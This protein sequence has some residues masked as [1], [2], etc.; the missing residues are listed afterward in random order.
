MVRCAAVSLFALILAAA[1]TADAKC[2]MPATVFAPADGA[3]TAGVTYVFVPAYRGSTLSVESRHGLDTSID[4]VSETDSFRAY[5]V[6]VTYNHTDLEDNSAAAAY[7]VVVRSEYG[8]DRSA[9]YRLFADSRSDAPSELLLLEDPSYAK[10]A[11]TCSHTD[12]VLAR[13]TVDA[14]AYRIE[15]ARTEADYRAGEREVVVVPRSMRAF[16][17]DAGD[18]Q[19]ELGH[20]NCFGETVPSAALADVAYLG[21]VP[22]GDWEPGAAPENPIAVQSGEPPVVRYLGPAAVVVD[23]GPYPCGLS[24]PENREYMERTWAK[25]R[26]R[27]VPLGL[28]FAVAGALLGAGL[29][30]RVTRRLDRRVAARLDARSLPQLGLIAG[31]FAMAGCAALAAAG[32]LLAGTSAALAGAVVATRRDRT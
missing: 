2:A 19:L 17:G 23:P 1:H 3:D 18:A 14:W 28:L 20:L 32:G 11:W 31:V 12:S 21:I 10:S 9:S 5:R 25:K 4:V 22:L 29:G 6:S 27:R 7:T 16:W 15:W 24:L 13:P 26:E 8:P 30:A